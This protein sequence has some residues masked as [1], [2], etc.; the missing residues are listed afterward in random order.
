MFERITHTSIGFP[1]QAPQD[2]LAGI[3]AANRIGA[4]FHQP[5]NLHGKLE[6]EG[7]TCKPEG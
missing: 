7:T 5:F 6:G 4:N 1:S 3:N 2:Q